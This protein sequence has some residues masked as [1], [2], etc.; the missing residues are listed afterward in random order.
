MGLKREDDASESVV[1]RLKGANG[2][3]PAATRASSQNQKASREP[4][5]L[6]R[7]PLARPARERATL[8]QIARTLR[9]RRLHELAP[10]QLLKAGIAELAALGAR[11]LE[12][13]IAALERGRLGRKTRKS[14]PSSTFGAPD[15][16]VMI[17]RLPP[18]PESARASSMRIMLYRFADPEQ[19][20]SGIPPS[21]AHA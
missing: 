6:V 4:S 11:Q 10:S 12:R 19:F 5:A 18:E 21:P 20:R 13:A 3:A 8:E 7:E 16:G 17:P 15:G 14:V 2:S 9:E 1:S